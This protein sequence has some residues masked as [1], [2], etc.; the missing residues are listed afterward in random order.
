MNGFKNR[1]ELL[2]LLL[3][4]TQDI[5]AKIIKHVVVDGSLNPEINM[6]YVIA[7][8][9]KLDSRIFNYRKNNSQKS[10]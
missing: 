3:D 4:D 7:R 5:I 9:E 1:E 2:D 10:L 8:L 6:E